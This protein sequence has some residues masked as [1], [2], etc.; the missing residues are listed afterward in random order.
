M[1]ATTIRAVVR[2]VICVM[3]IA[4]WI[5]MIF[6]H[7]DVPMAYQTVAC[8]AVLEWVSERAVKRFKEIFGGG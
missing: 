4:G 7:I 8:L 3:V 2:P 1:E 6:S 5:G